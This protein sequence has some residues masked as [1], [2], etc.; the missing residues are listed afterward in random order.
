MS[1]LLLIVGILSFAV[2]TH[3]VLR[4]QAIVDRHARRT[5]TG[6]TINAPAAYAVSGGLL[7]LAGVA[8]I[9]AAIA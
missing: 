3:N 1:I 5:A 9:A 6:H 7:A 8:M 4:R 2:G